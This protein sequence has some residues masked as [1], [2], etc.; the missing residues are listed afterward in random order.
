MTRKKKTA[1]DLKREL[2]ERAELSRVLNGMSSSMWVSKKIGC[3]ILGI[4]DNIC[5]RGLD[6]GLSAALDARNIRDP[7]AR[8]PRGELHFMVAW[9][10]H[11]DRREYEAAKAM[12]GD[13]LRQYTFA[14]EQ[15]HLMN[16]PMLHKPDPPTTPPTEEQKKRD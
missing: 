16:R 15:A 11:P 5:R 14:H 12:G 1:S 3:E 13:T 4:C 9:L 6:K 10:R 7:V 8:P 2:Q